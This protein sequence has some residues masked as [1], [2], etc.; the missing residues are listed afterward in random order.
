[1]S[2]SLTALFEA[3]KA[4]QVNAYCRYSG[5]HVGVALEAESGTIYSG[6][7]VEIASYPEGWCAETTA[8][9]K[10]VSAGERRIVGALVIGDGDGLTTPCGGCRQRLAEFAAADVP[11]HIAGAEGVRAT[12]TVGTL[13]PHGFVLKDEEGRS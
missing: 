8:I 11:V 1:M 4:A 13:L 12:F 5:F 3:A 10:M 9:G 2:A 6:C 7:N